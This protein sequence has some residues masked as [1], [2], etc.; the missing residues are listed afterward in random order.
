MHKLGP[1]IGK[2]SEN[3]KTIYIWS[4]FYSMH[5]LKMPL[6]FFFGKLAGALLHHIRA[7]GSKTVTTSRM[8]H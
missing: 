8:L 4:T 1:K 5:N 3:V 6:C 7:E 2:K